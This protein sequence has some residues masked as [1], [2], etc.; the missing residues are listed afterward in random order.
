MER[1]VSL[2]L[3]S[4]SDRGMLH[5]IIIRPQSNERIELTA[6]ELSPESGVMGDRW[7]QE[8][9]PLAADG[10]PDRRNQ[11][12]LMNVRIL[13]LIAG[14]KSSM[15]LAGD[16]LIVDFDLSEVNLPPGTRLR[17]GP[18]AIIELTD[19]PHV[20]CRKFSHRFGQEA[21]EFVNSPLGTRWNLRGRYAQV[22]QAGMIHVED[23]I[24]TI[25]A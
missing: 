19:V 13:A 8:E 1:N 3:E 16:N 15:Q 23:G 4:P 11:V 7:G 12:S 20:G 24:E 17:V 25:R 5:A 9:H 14:D 18:T 22:V 21:R 6:A 2:V 10:R